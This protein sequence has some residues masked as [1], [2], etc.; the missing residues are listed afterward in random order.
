[1]TVMP[2]LMLILVIFATF[3]TS[4]KNMCLNTGIL[5]AGIH[6]EMLKDSIRTGSYRSA[7]VNNAHLFEGKT[8]LDVGCGTGILS[9]FAAKAGAKHVV[10][11]SINLVFS[12]VCILITFRLTCRTLLIKPKKSLRPTASKTVSNYTQFSIVGFDNFIFSSDHPGQRKARRFRTSPER[13][14]YHHL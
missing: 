5:F 11:V 2:I 1:M 14:R 12:F 3:T 6:E 13:I 4:Y 7:I 9:M 10:G 8:V